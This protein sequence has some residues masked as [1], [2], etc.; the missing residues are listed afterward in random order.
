ML[1]LVAA[2]VALDGSRAIR[3]HGAR[4]R[5]TRQRRSA[6]ASR[7]ELLAEGA[8]DILA[9]ARSAVAGSRAKAIQ[10]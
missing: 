2:V 8:G 1:E 6:R 5:G 10:P 9:E 4:R 7:R 3:A